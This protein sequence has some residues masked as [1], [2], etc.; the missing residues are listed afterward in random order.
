MAED[1]RMVV[2]T[3]RALLASGAASLALSSAFG[4]L[5]S[6]TSACAGDASPSQLERTTWFEEEFAKLL[7]G[8][9]PTEG[10]IT[11][12]LPEIAENGNFVPVT[13][14]V[15]SPMT[16]KD[17]ITDV[18]VLSPEP[19]QWCGARAEPYAAVQNPGCRRA[20]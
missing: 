14:T 9:T 11:L 8:A 18:I 12:E 6:T 4:A 2:V 17:Y 13:I 1:V 16:E 19:A 3:R 15:E 5:I 10:K 20:R 7:A